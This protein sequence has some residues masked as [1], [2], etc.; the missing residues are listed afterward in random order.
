MK[1]AVVTIALNEAQFV[2]KWARSCEFADYRIVGDT[3][4]TDGTPEL[5][6]ANGCTVHSLSV[7]P[8][9]FDIARNALLA[10]VPAD[11]D[12]VINLD[13]DEVL[14]PGW[15]HH[16]EQVW[17][18]GV[19]RVFYTYVW[20]WTA[21]G[22][23]DRVFL[24]DKISGRHSH[25]WKLPVHEVLH[26]TVPEKIAECPLLR[27]HH[28]P[29][30]NK[31]RG[32]YLGLLELSFK[33]SPTC[34]RTAHYYGRELF[35]NGKYL[36]AI[37]Q[38]TRHLAMPNAQWHEERA[39]SMRYIARSYEALSE[40]QNAHCWYLRSAAETFDSEAHYALGEYYWNQGNYAGGYSHALAAMKT[41]AEATYL[42]THAA[43][44]WGPHDLA[45]RCAWHLGLLTVAYEEAKLAVEAYPECKRLQGNLAFVNDAIG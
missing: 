27:I 23:P 9:R 4:S 40:P 38:L 44:T 10:L 45:S 14:M 22:K 16:L 35:F 5:L 39:S 25:I 42:S 43:R 12:I 30:K 1:I 37:E 28:H 36:L 32:N 19:N 34:D 7:K 18:D 41:Q 31:S 17:K 6:R 15:R 3:G 21:E 2:E 8:W 24:S 20:S 33:E 29:D 11:T 26:A 13:L